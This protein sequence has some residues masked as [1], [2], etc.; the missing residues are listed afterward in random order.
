MSLYHPLVLLVYL[1]QICDT[2]SKKKWRFGL[3]FENFRNV[4]LTDI[5]MH[6][7]LIFRESLDLREMSYPIA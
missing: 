6:H 1:F 4:S 2:H 7:N 3:H 5:E